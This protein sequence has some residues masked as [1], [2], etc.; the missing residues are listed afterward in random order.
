MFHDKVKVEQKTDVKMRTLIEVL[1]VIRYAMLEVQNRKKSEL[2]NDKGWKLK[3]L[4]D[5][6]NESEKRG[7]VSGNFS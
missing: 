5:S 6:K 7:F 2:F 4:T 1:F 3:N